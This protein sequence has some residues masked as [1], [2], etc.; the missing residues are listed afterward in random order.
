[1]RAELEHWGEWFVRTT[2][3]DAFR[4][5]AVKHV[6]AGFLRDWLHAVAARTGRPLHAVGEYWSY[7][8]DTLAQFIAMTERSITLFD[9]P[10]HHNFH[11][12][13]AMGADYDLR[14]IFE[15][16]LVQRDAA[17]AVTLVENHDSQPL[18]ALE[19]VVEPWFKPLAYAL[20][21]LRRDGY[22]CIFHADCFG[23]EYSDA[24]ND[25]GTYDIELAPHRFLVD[26]FLHARQTHA[27]GNSTTTSTIR[28]ASAGRAL[29]MPRIPA[30]WQ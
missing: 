21:L 16:T 5:D 19:S 4:F 13:S 24:G 27:W 22:P 11:V 29:A 12:A 15:G 25:G 18:Q 10:L 17:M 7:D 26:R 30:G 9:A 23:A 20:I 6:E 1:V 14:T 28:T 3:V 8:V 2:G